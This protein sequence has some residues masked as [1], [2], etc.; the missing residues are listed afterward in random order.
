MRH[1]I[2]HCNN[3]SCPSASRCYRYQ[4]HLE[5]KVLGYVYVAYFD[6]TEEQIEHI[7][8]NKRCDS[9]WATIV[10]PEDGDK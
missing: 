8:V 6:F 4:A 1:D 7:K 9:F 10:L 5:A 2:A 3:S